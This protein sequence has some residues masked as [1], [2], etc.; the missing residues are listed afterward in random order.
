[1]RRNWIWSLAKDDDD[2]LRCIDRNETVLAIE[3]IF[4]LR[5]EMARTL[6]D[7]VHRR[8]MLGLSADQ[9]REMY[10]AIA[11]IAAKECAWD[12]AEA[13]SELAALVAYSDSFRL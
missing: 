3:V 5:E 2:L 11:A 8:M 9:G 6:V 13:A 12:A 4:S 7:I 1:M 10:A